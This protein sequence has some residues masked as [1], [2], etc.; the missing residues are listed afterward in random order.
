MNI[1]VTYSGE[2]LINFHISEIPAD[3]YLVSD[4]F[5]CIAEKVP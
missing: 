3:P 5:L 4:Q 1:F 2:L